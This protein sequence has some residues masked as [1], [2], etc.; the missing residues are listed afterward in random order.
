MATAKKKAP[1]KKAPAK[2]AAKKKAPAKKKAQQRRLQR[3]R[4]QLRRLP[5]RKLQPRRGEHAPFMTLLGVDN[6]TPSQPLRLC[7]QNGQPYVLSRDMQRVFVMN[8]KRLNLF[9]QE[10][11]KHSGFTLRCDE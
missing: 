10:R 8:K 4:H 11:K 9:F 6:S 3:R 5:R 1:A 7:Y 2:K